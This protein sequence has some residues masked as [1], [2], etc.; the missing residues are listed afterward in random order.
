MPIKHEVKI[1][2]NYFHNCIQKKHV[3]TSNQEP[4]LEAIKILISDQSALFQKAIYTIR[5]EAESNNPDALFILGFLELNGVCLPKNIQK[6][7]KHFNQAAEQKQAN[8]LCQLGIYYEDGYYIK[9]DSGQAVA[10]YERAAMLGDNIAQLALS[11]Y[12]RKGVIVAKDEK[13]AQELL[14]IV[15]AEM[16]PEFPVL[17][18]SAEYWS[19]LEKQV[20]E[21][22]V[23]FV[24]IAAAV[25]HNESRYLLGNYCQEGLVIAKSIT[26]AI[27]NYGLAAERG[28]KN[29]L[30]KLIVLSEAGSAE[31]DY[32][33]SCY[34]KRE[35]DN[36]FAQY[37][38]CLRKA[39]QKGHANSE[40]ELAVCYEQGFAVEKDTKKAKELYDMAAKKNHDA[41][42]CVLAN[43]YALGTLNI[44]LNHEKAIMLYR[45][46]ANMNNSEAC[47]RLGTYYESGIHIEK[48]MQK[49]LECYELSA[50]QGCDFAIDKLADAYR[51]GDLVAAN[52]IKAAE[53]YYLSASNGNALAQY[54]L[55][56]VY[57]EGIGVV[58]NL[59]KAIYWFEES[60]KD[61]YDPDVALGDTYYELGICY[62]T[63]N[64][65]DAIKKAAEYFL[66][67]SNE[68]HVWA[69]YYIAKYYLIGK[70]VSQDYKK[71][72]YHFRIAAESKYV[73]SLA[74]LAALYEK[75]QGVQQNIQ[76]AEKYYNEALQG[77]M[78]LNQCYKHF[79]SIQNPAI[80][81]AR[82][83]KTH[84]EN[85]NILLTAANAGHAIAQFKIAEYYYLQSTTESGKEYAL[86]Y[87]SL[88][89][90]Q[91]NIAALTHVG[92]MLEFGLAGEK[93]L[94]EALICYQKAAKG[95]DP[96]ANYALSIC[97][98][99]GNGVEQ[100]YSLAQ[101]YHAKA[102]QPYLSSP[103]GDLN[104]KASKE[105]KT[106][107]EKK[108]KQ[109]AQINLYKEASRQGHI[110]A[111]FVLGHLYET[112]VITD[113][114]PSMAIQMYGLAAVNG[115]VKAINKLE[116]LANDNHL[117]AHY[118][119]ARL[120]MDG[121]LQKA[122]DHLAICIQNGQNLSA[123]N[124]LESLVKHTKDPYAQFVLSN[125]LWEGCAIVIKNKKEAFSLLQNA[126]KQNYAPAQYKLA[127]LLLNPT[128]DSLIEED[129]RQAIQ[130][131][132]LAAKKGDILAHDQ[133]ALCYEQGIYLDIHL[134]KAKEHY[135]IAA[136]A[137]NIHAI[138]RLE[139]IKKDEEKARVEVAHTVLDNDS[140]NS[141]NKKVDESKILC[142]RTN[143]QRSA[144]DPT[145]TLRVSSPTTA[146][147]IHKKKKVL[148][149]HALEVQLNVKIDR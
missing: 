130:L 43:H 16:L 3:S 58:N 138:Q 104:N 48:S 76:I 120:Y 100:D 2:L 123:F 119:L 32:S 17:K 68:H 149:D 65:A 56:I 125:L 70:G 23:Q 91:G 110:E 147:D 96:V 19:E 105:A 35:Q 40:F 44:P 34:Y 7:F 51:F 129:C 116:S 78:D 103:A 136:D 127:I 63:L 75:G 92:I 99:E 108:V 107:A 117:H 140:N 94:A 45:A 90:S 6:A 71:A 11:Q 144:S 82:D 54:N 128:L 41:A 4:I 60:L 126:A 37:L 73:L 115:H 88:A 134:D 69:S 13:R 137:G 93:N 64:T 39:V 62:E 79:L 146:Y 86:H 25:G 20:S 50:Q 97:Y 148:M 102:L 84:V 57:K 30:E 111:Y 61:E 27:A 24:E 42:L 77:G 26:K 80:L 143:L 113:L 85:V 21:G 118:T 132:R 1:A 98:R 31:A 81:Q 72:V 9:Q 5:Q 135:Q 55:G 106:A 14:R 101:T 74:C 67:G 46:A 15:K 133:L 109:D 8:A 49:A 10:Y 33:L 122:I 12:Y 36:N 95:N 114:E 59:E 121:N 47:Y 52:F 89:A 145:A 139:A 131:L 112:E 83:L 29:S 38:S 22:A 142:E 87:F 124:D 66:L 18:Q 141:R 53:Y 28:C